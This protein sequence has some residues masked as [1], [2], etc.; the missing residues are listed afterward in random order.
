MSKIRRFDN[1][2]HSFSFTSQIENF[3]LFFNRFLE[4]DLGKIYS[5]IP[6]EALV[7]TFGLNDS[8]KGPASIFCPQGKL[9]LMFLKHYA[10]CSDKRLMEQLNGNINYQFFCGIHL[11]SDRLTNYKIVSEIRCELAKKLHIDK[12]QQVLFDSWSPYI[13][14]KHSIV[15]DVTC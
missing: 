3:D 7:N 5:A 2:Q 10:C 4:G 6:W 14:D 15:M 1:F 8:K 9:A 11:G 12:V 13:P